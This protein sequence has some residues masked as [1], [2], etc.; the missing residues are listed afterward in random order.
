MARKSANRK[1]ENIIRLQKEN[2][3]LRRKIKL[4]DSENENQAKQIKWFQKELNHKIETSTSSMNE[5]AKLD[6]ED[7]SV[8]NIVSEPTVEESVISAPSVQEPSVSDAIVTDSIP[9]NKIDIKAASFAPSST[10]SSI[11]S[12]EPEFKRPALEARNDDYTPKASF[13][14]KKPSNSKKK[15][16]D[17]IDISNTGVILTVGVV[18]LLLASIGFMSATWGLL[19]PG[20]RALFLLSLSGIFI[21]AGI[22]AKVKFKLPSTA[23]AF[24]SIGSATL[25][26]TIIGSSAFGLLGGLLTMDGIGGHITFALAFASLLILTVWG[27]HFFSSKVFA[28]ISLFCTT[29]LL[30]SIVTIQDIPEILASGILAVVAT[31]ITAVTPFIKSRVEKTNWNPYFKVLDIFSISNQYILSVMALILAD[32]DR[33]AGLFII[34]LGAGFL[35]GSFTYYKNSLI[36]IP[37]FLFVLAGSAILF[38]VE[39]ALSTAIWMM[40]SG[41]YMLVLSFVPIIKKPLN[42]IS[43]IGGLVFIAGSIF[44][45]IA[46]I[47]NNNDSYVYIP[48][49]IIAGLIYMWFGYM[50]KNPHFSCGPIVFFEILLILLAGSLFGDASSFEF[51]IFMFAGTLI[52][53]LAYILIKHP[54]YSV[55]GD[56]T[57]WLVALYSVVNVLSPYHEISFAIWSVIAIIFAVF[58]LF[59]TVLISKRETLF[60]NYL[61][62]FY[63]VAWT[64]VSFVGLMNIFDTFKYNEI[65][66]SY[67][68][69][70]SL[71]LAGLV[72]W[73]NIKKAVDSDRLFYYSSYAMLHVYTFLLL[74]YIND[75]NCTNICSVLRIISICIPVLVNA[76]II[77]INLKNSAINDRSLRFPSHCFMA[78]MG[79]G[80]SYL[81][82]FLTQDLDLEP[83]QLLWKSLTIGFILICLIGTLVAMYLSQNKKTFIKDNLNGLLNGVLIWTGIYEIILFFDTVAIVPNPIAIFWLC[84]GIWFLNILI[85]RHEFRIVGILSFIPLAAYYIYAIDNICPKDMSFAIFSTIHVKYLL[86]IIPVVICSAILALNKKNDIT[87]DSLFWGSLLMSGSILLFYSKVSALGLL[88]FIIVLLAYFIGS[89]DRESKI[90]ALCLIA[91]TASTAIWMRFPISDTDYIRVHTEQLYLIPTTLLMFTLPWIVR[92]F[93]KYKKQFIKLRLIYCY[94][95][96]AILGFMAL[97]SG[98][99]FD[100][101]SFAVIS[102]AIIVVAY[103]IH[104]R[105]YVILGAVCTLGFMIY[106]INEVVGGMAWL[107]YLTLAGLVLIGV[108]VRNEIKRRNSKE[109]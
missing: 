46:H 40:I 43:S 88:G 66:S 56:I 12:M 44:P 106:L 19:T 28:L 35:L 83:G 96:M 81:S 41:I 62:S 63:K 31:V 25:P 65:V 105:N 92:S 2:L 34:I 90:R 91:V 57:F 16:T 79:I 71:I 23:L 24:Y 47:S 50:K 20:I 4:L 102:T 103:L 58:T 13:T 80:I 15:L 9:E 21:G 86:Y 39:S 53:Y 99:L 95:A 3:D 101:I 45:L 64:L 98:E 73:T 36:S 14:N 93:G 38:D 104:N 107:V 48:F 70:F 18:L 32:G 7:V 1:Q 29:C 108:A 51:A 52:G 42:K 75:Y 84:I 8:S 60:K 54:M 22:L 87:K 55:F 100:L 72:I 49:L 77:F 59:N 89:K 78:S 17:L 11:P 37:H 30:I 85:F 67:F 68:I 76:F 10:L 97:D 61:L 6:S 5:P 26:I 27:A 74:P 33:L 69:V 109:S 94:V 82:G